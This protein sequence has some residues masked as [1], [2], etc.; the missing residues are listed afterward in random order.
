M[1][2]LLIDASYTAAMTAAHPGSRGTGLVAR[3]GNPVIAA[4]AFFGLVRY[5]YPQEIDMRL[6]LLLLLFAPALSATVALKLDVE[7]LTDKSDIIVRAKI[8][9]V[10]AR[11]NAAN[12]GIW[13]HHALTV[14]ATLKGEHEAARTFL[15]RGGAVGSKAQHVA[16]SGNFKVGEEFVLFLWRDEDKNLQLVGMVQG[17]LAIKDVEG[18]TRAVG[19]FAG[20]TLVNSELKPLPESDRTPLDFKYADLT[21]KI[22]ARIKAEAK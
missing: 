4:L 19:S 5:I 12:T 16:G 9:S 13:T 21:D 6:L 8:D 11:W 7:T 17:A 10:E 14:S 2:W 22:S 1:F 3:W 18:V 20:L 15:T